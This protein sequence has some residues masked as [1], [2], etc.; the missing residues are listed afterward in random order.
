[1]INTYIPYI[2]KRDK[3]Y[4]TKCL[5]SNFVSTAG[6]KVQ[7]FEKAF[8]KIFNFKNA[9]ALNSGTSALHLALL[10]SGVQKDE[11]VIV[12]SYTFAATAN[13]INYIGAKPWFFDCD[14]ELILDLKKL[15]KILKKK[16]KLKSNKLVDKSS[17][18][19]VKAIIP[20]QTMG[21]KIDFAKFERFAK[22]YC[23][24]IIFDSAACHDPKIMNFK[25]NKNSIFCFSF[26]GNKT[27]TTGAGGMIATNSKFLS[28]KVR[29]FANVG[30]KKSKY[31]YQ[32]IG[33][34]YKMTNMQASLGLSQLVS[35]KEILK[36]KG[37]IFKIYKE[38]LVDNLN[39][40][41]INDN[42]YINWVFALISKNKNFFIKI[43]KEFNT[44]KIQ[45]DYFWKPL[46][47]QS[48]YKKFRAEKC[49]ISTEIWDKIILLPS[50]PS[51]NKK[52]QEKI[53]GILNK[54][55]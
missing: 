1:M 55:I 52:D 34:N 15:E 28:E 17:G 46:H 44:K 29:I 23:L 3:K 16:T 25:K 5:N 20:V 26:N 45:L 27:I 32:Q 31:D 51:I 35:L 36:K 48:P 9:V 39:F 49:N 30:K 40:I 13:V 14:N 4:I 11:F 43:K 10:S 6:P 18:K 54:S 47:L 7:D 50:H 8:S 2:N 21:R 41:K 19:I 12:P 22:K 38:L 33:F 37:D 24:K 53:C 42:G